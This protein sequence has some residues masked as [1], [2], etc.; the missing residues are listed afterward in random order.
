[1]DRGRFILNKDKYRAKTVDRIEPHTS[2]NI[3]HKIILEKQIIRHWLVKNLPNEFVVNSHSTWFSHNFCVKQK[4][5]QFRILAECIKGHMI[6][7][8]DNTIGCGFNILNKYSYSVQ[9]LENFIAQK[10]NEVQNSAYVPMSMQHQRLDSAASLM[11][12]SN[13]L[14]SNMSGADIQ[15]FEKKL[16]ERPCTTSMVIKSTPYSIER[17]ATHM[18]THVGFGF[19]KRNMIFIEHNTINGRP[20]SQRVNYKK[21]D[22]DDSFE[23]SVR[24]GN[25]LAK[26]DGLG[27]PQISTL[28][29]DSNIFDN[30]NTELLDFKK[31][32]KSNRIAEIF[33]DEKKKLNTIEDIKD[34]INKVDRNNNPYL[35]FVDYEKFNDDQLID[36]YKKK[37]RMIT[38]NLIE[39]T[40]HADN[41]ANKLNSAKTT[42]AM[43][44]VPASATTKNIDAC[45]ADKDLRKILL[46]DEGNVDSRK[47]L[48]KDEGFGVDEEENNAFG[49]LYPYV[50]QEFFS[51]YVL[52]KR[53]KVNVL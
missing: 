15:N 14:T 34:H 25:S 35:N 10:F 16:K 8:H 13:R 46:K 47:M 37:R 43:S 21:R 26:G 18:A 28:L 41:N 27:N 30:N 1:V 36:F 53:T 45:N 44:S 5:L 52:D 22:G 4:S 19:S 23:D 32:S 48:H 6:I 9:I 39:L 7:E 24:S 42:R 3:E 31:S 49:I 11:T 38:Q 20:V 17:N 33:E 51:K 29:K 12:T 2:M 50:N 40:Y